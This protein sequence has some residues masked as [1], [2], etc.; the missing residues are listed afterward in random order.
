MADPVFTPALIGGAMKGVGAVVNWLTG[1]R[2]GPVPTDVANAATS[3]GAYGNVYGKQANLNAPIYAQ[4]TQ[5]IDQGFQRAQ[6]DIN[7]Y[8][9]RLD[10]SRRRAMG[11]VSET[12]NAGRMNAMNAQQQMMGQA[13]SIRGQY[14]PS[15]VSRARME[16]SQIPIMGAAQMRGGAID[17]RQRALQAWNMGQQ[18]LLGQEQ[19]MYGA[20]RQARALDRMQFENEQAENMGHIG[21]AAQ[22]KEDEARSTVDD[23]RIH[24]QGS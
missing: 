7:D 6:G 17:E 19:S 24:Y 16:A 14:N 1:D 15:A 21:L 5:P 12:M 23:Q 3:Q 11:Q 4:S 10:D 18:Q 13:A 22:M 2:K 8:Q 9:A 20:E